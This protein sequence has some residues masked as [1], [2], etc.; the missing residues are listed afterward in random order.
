MKLETGKGGVEEYQKLPV[1]DFIQQYGLTTATEVNAEGITVIPY[2]YEWNSY[3]T[4]AEAQASKDWPD[5]GE[6][7]Q[8]VNQS[9]Q[10]SAKAKSYQK[11]IA[12]LKSAFEKSPA[13]RQKQFV[14]SAMA[15]G[16]SRD[17]ADALA[18]SKIS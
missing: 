16:F 9:A 6:I 15:M 7:L 12:D 5:E 3:Q 18:K 8:F 11:A 17:E 10:R 2:P 13:F 4:V 1:A 14:E